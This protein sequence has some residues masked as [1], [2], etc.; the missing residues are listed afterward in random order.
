MIQEESTSSNS[1]RRKVLVFEEKFCSHK[2]IRTFALQKFADLRI[3][4][5]GYDIDI[6][7]IS[8][9]NKSTN[10]HETR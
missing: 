6:S 7:R 3:S 5:H 10:E 4:L 8:S 2:Y 1:Y 9:M